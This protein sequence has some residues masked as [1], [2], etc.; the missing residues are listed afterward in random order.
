MAAE[1]RNIDR[2]R[3]AMTYGEPGVELIRAIQGVV[4]MTTCQKRMRLPC[5]GA[6]ARVLLPCAGARA[7]GVLIRIGA[8]AA[9]ALRW[10]KSM[11]A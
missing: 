8:T 9:V 2:T 10:G 5:A 3:S 7:D 11:L 1:P 6:R 4:R